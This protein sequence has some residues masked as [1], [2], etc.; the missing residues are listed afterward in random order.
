MLKRR[1]KQNLSRNPRVEYKKQQSYHYSSRRSTS[2]RTFDRQQMNVDSE[3]TGNSKLSFVRNLPMYVSVILILISI[4]YLL[5]LSVKAQITVANNNAKTQLISKEI[6]QK[7]AEA[8][9][10]KNVFNRFKPTFDE[11]K[12]ENELLGV[13]PEI[14]KIIVKTSGLKHRVQIN[15]EFSEPSLVLSTGS[16]LYVVGSDGKVLADI[17]KSKDGF[18]ISNLPLV[19]DQSNIKI[20][21]GKIALTSSQVEYIQQIK[22]QTDQK[23]N[24]STMTLIPGGTEL[25]VRYAGLSYYVKY[26]F[27][28]NARQSSGVFLA[29]KEKFDAD[30]VIPAEYIDVRVPERAYIK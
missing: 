16:N 14:T 26:N 3:K 11:R 17:T 2:D 4:Y 6:L 19:Q 23:I 10:R 28:E 21:V 5:T 25:D 8:E 20:V 22:Y 9:L 7:K 13:S 24:T 18:D 12:L 1:K 15:V 27:F 30:G 29:A